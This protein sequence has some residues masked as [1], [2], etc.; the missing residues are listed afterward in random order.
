MKKLLALLTAV[1]VWAGFTCLA[2]EL[3]SSKN[4]LRFEWGNGKLIILCDGQGVGEFVYRDEKIPRPFFANLRAPGGIQV[5]RNYPPQPGK[6]DMDHATVHPGV[7]LAFGDV[8]GQDFWRNR[9]TIRH[10]RFTAEPAVREGRLSFATE[11]RMLTTE[12]QPICTLHSQFTFSVRPAGYLLI[13]DAVFHAEQREIVF[14]DQEEMGLGVRVATPIAE[15]NGGLIVSS[16][17][18][19]TARQTWGKAY[20][21]CDYSGV[22]GGQRVGITL[23]TDPSN[24]RPSWFHNRDYGLMVANPFGRKSMK[25]G[26]ESR[27]VVQ[28]GDKLRLCFGLLLHAGPTEQE[29]DLAAAYRDF[30]EQLPPR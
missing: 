26:E 17:G 19:K 18:D 30:L 2:A 23:M 28:K 25:Q 6:D 29:L 15:R 1:G 5:T 24:F 7:W 3:A 13:W 9:A 27:V 16:S 12:G 22:V 4:E 21:W 14:G 10:E 8:N 11:S 20:Q